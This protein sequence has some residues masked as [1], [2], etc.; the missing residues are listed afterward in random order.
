MNMALFSTYVQYVRILIPECTN[1][2]KK[3]CS[4]NEL[5]QRPKN[6]AQKTIESEKKQSNNEFRV[7]G[8]CGLNWGRGRTKHIKTQDWFLKSLIA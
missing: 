8:H 2:A 7:N 6:G 1:A 5:Q 4:C 3:N